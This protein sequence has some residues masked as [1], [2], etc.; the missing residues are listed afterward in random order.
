MNQET[1]NEQ[2]PAT[3]ART[4]RATPACD[5]W[6]AADG[7]HVV[8]EMPGVDPATVEVLVESD[9][10]SIRGR[11]ELPRPSARAE[12]KS[13]TLTVEYRRAFQLTETADADSIEA[14]CKDG[15]VRVLV[16]RKKPAQRKVAVSVG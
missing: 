14:A 12:E 4:A 9:V 13:A 3:A 6:E 5:V 15:L 1:K 16:P 7:V 10:L 11:A 2:T 8:A